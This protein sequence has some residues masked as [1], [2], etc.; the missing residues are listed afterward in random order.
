[1]N[2]I[3]ATIGTDG[4]VFPDLGLG[5]SILKRGHRV[6]LAAPQTYRDRATNLGMD[7]ESLLS[8]ADVEQMLSNPYR[9]DPVRSGPMM[10]KWGNPMI[11]HQYKLLASLASEPDRI[12][13][14][15]PGV[16]LAQQQRLWKR[17]VRSWSSD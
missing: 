6:T 12:M 5:S 14:A 13:V 1:M 10:A 11:P 16:G 15:N 17:H 9:G 3:L 2:V 8:T 4:D 7:F